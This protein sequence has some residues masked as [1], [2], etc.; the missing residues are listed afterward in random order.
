MEECFEDLTGYIHAVETGLSSDPAMNWRV[1]NLD[2]YQLISNSDAH[3]PGKLGR[4]ANLMD[5]ELSYQGLEQA[6]QT[7]EGLYGTIEFFPE[8]GKYHY[9]GHRKCH[10]CLNPAQT[11]AYGGRCPG[12]GKK[13][14]IGVEHRVEALADRPEGYVRPQAKAYESLIPLPEIIAEV[15][16]HSSSSVKVQRQYEEMLCGLGTEF[17]ILR[18]VPEEEIQKQAGTM[19]AEAIRRLRNGEVQRIPGF[20]G[21]YGTI[22]LFEPSELEE[23]QG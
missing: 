5:M 1:S 7:G 12:C 20:D 9:D 16:G 2:R 15:T 4:E 22:K 14:T 8:E 23:T 6:V 13:I 3:S 19:M 17:E 21:E 18:E 10:L 11:Q